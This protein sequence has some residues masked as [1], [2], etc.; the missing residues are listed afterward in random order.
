MKEEI[1]WKKER[2]KDEKKLHDWFKHM[3]EVDEWIEQNP[4]G[5]AKTFFLKWNTAFLFFN[6][7]N[8]SL[9]AEFMNVRD[10][11][12]EEYET[13]KTKTEEE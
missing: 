3:K 4:E 5:W 10:Q 8:N 13:W 1:T 11:I 7:H 6:D 2:Y 9:M 12:V